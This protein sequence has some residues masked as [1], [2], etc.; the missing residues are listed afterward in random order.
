MLPRCLQLSDKLHV[1]V[2]IYDYEGYGFSDGYNTEEALYCDIEAVFAYALGCYYPN[3]IF[4][5]GESSML[6][7]PSLIY[8]W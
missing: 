2:I 6:S 1:D 7:F 3:S 5:Y 8:S 4:L